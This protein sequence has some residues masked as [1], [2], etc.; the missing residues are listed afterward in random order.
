[1]FNR[2]KSVL[3]KNITNIPGFKTDRKIIVIE[4]DDWGSIR[5]PNKKVLHQYNAMGYDLNKNPYCKYDTLANTDDLSA[6]FEVLLRYKDKIGSHPKFT[7]NTVMA[8]PK[9]DKIKNM[10]YNEY[11]HEPF[12]ETIKE[13]YPKQNVFNIWKQGI[14]EG[15]IYPQFHGREHINVPVWL[16]DLKLGSPSLN[17]AFDLNF[18]GIP[19]HLYGDNKVNIQAAFSSADEEHFDFYKN[20]IIEGTTM[21][22][23]I[24]GFKSKTFI[25]NNYTYPETLNKTLSNSGISGIQGMKYQKIPLKEGGIALKSVHTGM[26]NILNQTYTVRNCIFEPS[27][28]PVK[29]DNVRSCIND[30]SNSFFWKKPAILTS[31]RLNYIGSIEEDNRNRNLKLLNNL[32]QTILKKWPDVEFMTSDQLVD[33][34]KAKNNLDKKLNS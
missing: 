33:H 12:T 27:Q 26:K 6:L 10:G 8:N 29:L 4:S 22:E 11:F 13:Y 28:M 7:F 30:I 3:S 2:V 18:W 16:N 5:M 25:A 23:N 1:M 17:A 21:F 32:I 9:F 20:N 14:S 31:H 34:I 19:K 15:L 24:F